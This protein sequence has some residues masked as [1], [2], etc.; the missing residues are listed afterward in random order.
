MLVPFAGIAAMAAA[1]AG[2][3]AAALAGSRDPPLLHALWFVFA[4]AGSCGPVAY[5]LVAQRFPPALTGRVATAMNGSMLV[6]VFLLQSGI[7]LILDLWPRTAS[8]GWDP[9]GYAVAMG[10]TLAL[11]VV[12]VLWLLFPRGGRAWPA[13]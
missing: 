6:L 12:S 10:L 5:T 8:G 2:L 4:A 11:Q 3:I 9:A 7:G 1:Q 13:T